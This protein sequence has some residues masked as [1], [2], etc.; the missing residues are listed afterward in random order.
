MIERNPPPGGIPI[1][2]VPS[3]RTVCKRTLEALGTKIFEGGPLTPASE[4]CN[5]EHKSVHYKKKWTA[6]WECT[7][8]VGAEGNEAGRMPSSLK[9]TTKSGARAP[10]ASRMTLMLFTLCICGAIFLFFLRQFCVCTPQ[11]TQKTP[12]PADRPPRP[13][14]YESCENI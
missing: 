3:S 2:Y 11:K 14:P 9:V 7:A 13:R 10:G 1:Y 12:P 6:L 5:W 8:V 4:N